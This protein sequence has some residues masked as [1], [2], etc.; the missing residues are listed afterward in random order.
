MIGKAPIIIGIHLLLF[1]GMFLYFAWY[2]MDHC[3][4]FSVWEGVSGEDCAAFDK[5]DSVRYVANKPQF[6]SAM[7]FLAGSIVVFSL[8]EPPLEV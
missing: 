1:F 2:A 8:H 6:L 5:T 7:F 4:F 3:V